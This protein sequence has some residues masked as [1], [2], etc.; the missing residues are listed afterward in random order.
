MSVNNFFKKYGNRNNELRS[1]VHQFFEFGRNVS[2]SQSASLSSGL[3]QDE[4][5]RQ[6]AYIEAAR[7]LIEKISS[8]VP[9]RAATHPNQFPINMVKPY[10]H[11]VEDVNGDLKPVNEHTALLSEQWLQLAVNLAE[12]HSAQFS[13]GIYE[14]DRK[15]ADENLD[16]VEAWVEIIEEQGAL[17]MPETVKG[18]SEFAPSDLE[19]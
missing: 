4:I 3:L 15:R 19:R 17:D 12:S 6:K 13:G 2:E 5:T 16:R 10:K 1:M 11:F 18:S 9:D 7:N 14:A 8:K